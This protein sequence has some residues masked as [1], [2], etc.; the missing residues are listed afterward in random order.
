M[1]GTKF[2]SPLRRLLLYGFSLFFILFGLAGLFAPTMLAARLHLAPV[3][4][5]GLGE[6]RGLYGGG[7]TGFGLVILAGLRCKA[8]GAGLLLAM[9]IIAA[10]IAAGRL[11][12]LATDH[13]TGFAAPAALWEF[14]LAAA[15]YF[16]SRQERG[17]A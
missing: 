1:S 5:A 8:A 17:G 7:F 2:L 9:G 13:D 4:N 10:G 16:E 14:I 15:C 3:N 11:V 12:S 6:L